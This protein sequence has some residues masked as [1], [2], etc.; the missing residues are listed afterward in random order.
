MN[1]DENPEL[2]LQELHDAVLT[3]DSYDMAAFA[4]RWGLSMK[5]DYDSIVFSHLYVCQNTFF[6]DT[7]RK[8]ST[9]WLRDRA[10]DYLITDMQVL[11]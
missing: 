5:N 2:F 3:H 6:T 7:E 9:Q 10:L 4:K 11:Q 8:T 1:K